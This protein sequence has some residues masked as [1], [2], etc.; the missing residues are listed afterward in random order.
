VLYG[1]LKTDTPKYVIELAWE[2]RRNCTE[3]EQREDALLKHNI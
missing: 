1:G 3:L 2:Q